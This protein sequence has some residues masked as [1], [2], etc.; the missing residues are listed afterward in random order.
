MESFDRFE[1]FDRQRCQRVCQSMPAVASIAFERDDCA[2][3]FLV[4]ESCFMIVPVGEAESQRDRTTGWI[5]RANDALPVTVLRARMRCVEVV[6]SRVP[7]KR[8]RSS[9]VTVGDADLQVCNQRYWWT[10]N[11]PDQHRMVAPR[12]GT[13]ESSTHCQNA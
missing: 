2:V 10:R 6:L 12:V 11:C 5:S 7:V 13:M 1:F 4:D 3:G 9:P 8:K